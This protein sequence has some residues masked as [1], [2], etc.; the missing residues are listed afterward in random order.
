MP[1]SY[2]TMLEKAWRFAKWEIYL[3]PVLGH[4]TVRLTHSLSLKIKTEQ[5]PVTPYNC[6]TL[7]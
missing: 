6:K 4:K 7:N 2:Y 3:C 5:S 1:L